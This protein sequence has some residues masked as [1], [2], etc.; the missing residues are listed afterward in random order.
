M[1]D[2]MPGT[3]TVELVVSFPEGMSDDAEEIDAQT[4]RLRQ[5]LAELDV[6][7]VELAPGGP[8]PAGSKSAEVVALG[9][10][11]V[12]LLPATL[13]KVLE[14]LNSWIGRNAG[15][16]IKIRASAG[17]RT[18]EVEYSPGAISERDLKDLVSSIS[19]I[20]APA[21]TT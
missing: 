9:T 21:G 4:R 6:E 12:T 14:L 18:V 3:N 17:D 10:L 5:R 2:T 11:L 13:P 20:A 7:S 8:A 1:R 19:G 15:R 16:S